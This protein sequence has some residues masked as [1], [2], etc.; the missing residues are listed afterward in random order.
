MLHLDDNELHDV[1]HFFARRFPSAEHRAPLLNAANLHEPSNPG[2]PWADILQEAQRTGRMRALTI[3]A[4]RLAPDD[5][6][7]QDVCRLLQ[8]PPSRMSSAV[9]IASGIAC[10]LVVAVIAGPVLRSPSVAADAH[11]TS[12]ASPT[13]H[14]VVA[15]NITP[16][17]ANLQIISKTEVTRTDAA[18]PEPE[19]EAKPEP[20][21]APAPAAQ[22][23]PLS[24]DSRC[25][26]G[27]GELAGYWYA[28]AEP[29]GAKGD[30][31]VVETT[32]NVRV[33]YPD[34]HNDYDARARVRCLIV[35]GDHITLSADPIAVPGERYW[36]P[37]YGGDLRQGS[38]L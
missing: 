29:P 16:P 25:N 18:P 32:A 24:L 1:A 36:V 8:P 17:R 11:T 14:A 5:E 22:D 26:V 4:R 9:A 7:L 12:A 35:A 31:I 20:T 2:A 28:G 15:A 19:P 3:A 13:P 34:T 27:R 10:A 37:L 21:P 6:N 23:V 33:D 30:T 38:P